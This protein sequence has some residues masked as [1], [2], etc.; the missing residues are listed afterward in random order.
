[1]GAESALLCSGVHSSLNGGAGAEPCLSIAHCVS[2][3]KPSPKSGPL[4]PPGDAC[5]KC[6]FPHP[7][8][9]SESLEVLRAGDLNSLQA[10][11]AFSVSSEA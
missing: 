9:L 3:N 2:A 8:L 4:G 11:Q 6:S 7:T 5:D 10:P 1:M